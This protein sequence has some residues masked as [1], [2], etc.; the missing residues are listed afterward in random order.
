M[1]SS[2]SSPS[3]HVIAELRADIAASKQY[4]ISTFP[5]VFGDGTP[6]RK[7]QQTTVQSAPLRKEI[8]KDDLYV[9]YDSPDY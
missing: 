1:S 4:F 7:K 5:N 2:P 8:K 3:Q 6:K 9:P